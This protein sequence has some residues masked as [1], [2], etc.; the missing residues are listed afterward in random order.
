MSLETKTLPAMRFAAVRHSGPYNEIG[1]A[2]HTL[3][4]IAGK[5]ALFEKP[6]ALMIG[7]Y[8]DDPGTT[9]PQDLRSAAVI[10]IAEDTVIPEGLV[11]ERVPGGRFA[12]F[13]H[14]GSYATLKDSWMRVKTELMPTSGY[15]R[16]PGPAY[17]IYINNPAQVAQDELRTEICVPIS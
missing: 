5:A 13:M 12:C 8:K 6:G 14:K 9:S 11:E 17:E 7:I 16:R 2:F 3:G 4:Q 15:R 1:P 10:V